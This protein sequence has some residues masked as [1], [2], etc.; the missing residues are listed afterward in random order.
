MKDMIPLPGLYYEDFIAA[1]QADRA[2]NVIP[3]NDKWK[4]L[5]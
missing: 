5:E 4:H 1:N 2:D 3:G